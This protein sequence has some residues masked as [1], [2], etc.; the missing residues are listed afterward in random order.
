MSPTLV[1][2]CGEL[3]RAGVD[4]LRVAREIA[5]HFDAQELF[6]FLQDSAIGAYL[7]AVGFPQ[8]LPK[9]LAWQRFLAAVVAS[10]EHRGVLPFPT[11]DQNANAVGLGDASGFAVVLLGGGTRADRID[12]LR[13]V[14]PLVAFGLQQERLAGLRQVEAE[15]AR[16]SAANA[17]RLAET[18][19]A[20]R[21]HWIATS[22][23]LAPLRIASVRQFSRSML[24]G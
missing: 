22:S 1:K 3:V 23:S 21:R 7:P 12:E 9:G 20:V 2:L 5:K 6:V 14:L 8:T 17:Q 13:S 18:V 24:M 19:D 11:A 16:E 10:R 15:V 4:R